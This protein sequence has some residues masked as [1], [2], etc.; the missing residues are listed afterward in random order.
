MQKSTSIEPTTTI[1][2]ME[3]A[4]AALGEKIRLAKLN[5]ARDQITQIC[6]ANPG[7][8]VQFTDHL[9]APKAS[10]PATPAVNGGSNGKA[11]GN[12]HAKK[13]R[14]AKGAKKPVAIKYRN[15]DNPAETWSGR[16]RPA[17]WIAAGLKAG[18]PMDYY[19]VA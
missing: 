1:P 17:K 13:A 11:N 14:K 10:T 8:S 18:K 3:T 6:K 4:Y 9:P 5:Q 2:Q 7:L 16:G 15:P 12:G 19:R